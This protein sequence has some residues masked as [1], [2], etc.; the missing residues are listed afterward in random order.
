MTAHQIEI[1]ID[2]P[3]SINFIDLRLELTSW[4]GNSRVR[5]HISSWQCRS[6]NRYQSFLSICAWSWPLEVE[7]AQ[8]WT[9]IKQSMSI[10]QPPSIDFIDFCLDLSSWGRVAQQGP[11]WADVTTGK[12]YWSADHYWL[13]LP[14]Y[15]QRWLFEMGI[16]RLCRPVYRFHNK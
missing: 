1:S 10:N 3:P 6:P 9:E 13:I 5:T 8:Y 11:R 15:M 4:G 2:Q 12:Q 14:A 7:V 16:T